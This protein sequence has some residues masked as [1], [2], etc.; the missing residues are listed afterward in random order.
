MPLEVEQVFGDRK[1][2]TLN[3]LSTLTN[4]MSKSRIHYHLLFAELTRDLDDEQCLSVIRLL[5]KQLGLQHLRE[6]VTKITIDCTNCCT[7]NI[8]DEIYEVM[9]EKIEHKEKKSGDKNIETKID[10]NITFPLLR[11]PIDLI[12]HTSFYLN[13]NDIFKFEQC[14]RAFYKMINNSIYLKDSNN[15]QIFTIT[16]KRLKQMTMAQYNFFKYSKAK[17]LVVSV[18]V[19]QVKMSYDFEVEELVAFVNE[20]E[21]EWKQAQYILKTDIWLVNLFQSIE[22]LIFDRISSLIVYLLPI[23]LLFDPIV[24]HL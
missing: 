14:C 11:L 17:K 16:R 9:Q 3:I 13:E 22:V 8:L 12:K 6:F 15:F 18:E 5:Q 24:S 20:F 10:R 7:L 19:D 1:E 23:E 4:A 21:Q 2:S